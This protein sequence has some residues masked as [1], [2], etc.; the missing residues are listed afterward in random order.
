[1]S[2]AIVARIKK[3]LRADRARP[4]LFAGQ[5]ALTAGD[6]LDRIDAAEEKLIAAGEPQKIALALPTSTEALAFFIAALNVGE[7]TIYFD[8]NWAAETRAKIQ[9]HIAPDLVIDQEGEL[10]LCGSSPRR[11]DRETHFTCFTS[12]STGLPKGCMRTEQ[13]WLYSFEADQDFSNI[14]PQSTIIVAGSFAHSLFTYAALR[15]LVAGA[16]ILLLPSFH[17]G[18]IF[19]HAATHQNAVLFA[20]P[21]Q[22]VALTEA[23][24]IAPQFCKILTT[25]SKLSP[26]LAAKVK[27][28]FPNADLIEFYGTSELSYVAARSVH[29]DDAPSLVGQPLSSVQIEIL[30]AEMQTLAPGEI[31]QVFVRSPMAFKGY[32]TEGGFAPA[33][34]KISVGDTG[35]MD[36]QGQLH[37]QGRADRMLQVSGRN[38]APEEIEAALLAL[39]EVNRAAIFGEA[40]AKRGHRIVAVVQLAQPVDRATLAAALRP[41]LTPY[42]MPQRFYLCDNWPHTSSGKTDLQKLAAARRTNSVQELT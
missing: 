18:A 39:P 28:C 30:D 11:A 41:H 32:L 14:T 20:V 6:L 27:T 1:M 5:E 2:A 3:H 31:G 8:P 7:N 40:D 19:R 21:T 17:P 24:Q 26:E 36:E 22:L 38:V 35:F 13:S 10:S 33:A 23:G 34:D 15:G 29:P 4:T 25:G 16:K 37:L 12:G 42:L 9:R